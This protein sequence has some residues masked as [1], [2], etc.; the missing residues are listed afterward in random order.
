MALSPSLGCSEEQLRQEASRA[1]AQAGTDGC[2]RRTQYSLI[3][4][5]ARA[6]DGVA[7][8]MT[9]SSGSDG[10][11][12]I[13]PTFGEGLSEMPKSFCYWPWTEKD[14]RKPQD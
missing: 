4:E 5:A 8:L 1:E 13:S 9:M 3:D 14:R 7:R 10:G 2:W 12:A 11:L 6:R